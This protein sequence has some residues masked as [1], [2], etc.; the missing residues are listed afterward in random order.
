MERFGFSFSL[1]SDAETAST[2]FATTQPQIRLIKVV[3][4]DLE[5]RFDHFNRCQLWGCMAVGGAEARVRLW[6]PSEETT[7]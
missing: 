3:T 1:L 2:V 4:Q 7:P 5:F 6:L